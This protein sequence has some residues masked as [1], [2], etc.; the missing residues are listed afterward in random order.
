MAAYWVARSTVNNPDQYKKYVGQFVAEVFAGVA[1]LKRLL[2]V[3]PGDDTGYFAYFFSKYSH[4]GEFAE[5]AHAIFFYPVI[6]Q[7]LR[8]LYGHRSGFISRI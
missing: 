2:A 7:L 4:V 8:V 5:V 6:Y 3:L 1:S